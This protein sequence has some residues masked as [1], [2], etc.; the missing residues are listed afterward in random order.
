M[1]DGEAKLPP[2][3]F[4]GA[5]WSVHQ[6]LLGSDGMITIPVGCFLVR[7][8]G[9][10]VLIDAG[11]GPIENP[12]FMR[13]GDLP[14]KL[15]ANGVK[16]SDVDIVLCTHLHPDHMGWVVRDGTPFFSNATVRFGRGDW[17]HFVT[18]ASPGDYPRVSIEFLQQAGRIATVEGDEEVAPGISTL[19]APGHTP[20]HLCVVLSSGAERAFLLGDAVTCPIQLQEAEWQAMSDVDKDLAGRTREALWRELEG[21]GTLTVAAH[22]PDLKFGRI[23]RGEGK[24]YFA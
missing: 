17:D 4:E 14:G 8:Q 18:A 12:P 5:D 22:F 24:R 11:W 7:T 3:Y 20:G 2:Q 21:S 23:L 1:S 6:N 19:H 10:L 16:P 15:E 9:Q 13:G